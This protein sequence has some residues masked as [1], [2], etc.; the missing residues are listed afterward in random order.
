VVQKT[1]KVLSE[2]PQ[3]STPVDQHKCE[4]FLPSTS[5]LQ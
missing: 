1:I 2:K 4:H 5:Q 3:T